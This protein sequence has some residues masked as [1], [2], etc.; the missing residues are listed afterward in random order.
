[1]ARA[2]YQKCLATPGPFGTRARL[3]LAEIDLAEGQF[4]D[5]ERAFQD[6]LQAVRG[7]T[8]PDAVLQEHAV[9]GGA[10]VADARPG[11]VK[12]EL[13]EYTTAEQR[14]LGALQQ[15]PES[16]QA[17]AAHRLLG[18]CYWTEARLKSEALKVR[19]GGADGLTEAERRSYQQK[20]LE[21]LQKSAE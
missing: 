17:P 1:A 5:A 13:R 12:E 20:R 4:D 19:P 18:L 2:A 16:A 9:Y 11:V 3:G 7:A 10:R 14:L 15:Y 8:E 21:L 6:V